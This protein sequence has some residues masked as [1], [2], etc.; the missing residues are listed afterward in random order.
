MKVNY[1]IVCA[2][3][4]E[5]ELVQNKILGQGYCWS[6]GKKTISYKNKP[7]LIFDNLNNE[8]RSL[9]YHN[10]LMSDDY[11]I[12]SCYNKHK[13]ISAMDFLKLVRF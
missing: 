1:I 4:Y 6:E 7:V 11:K 8:D 5:N 10:H 2:D 9:S 13:L 12:N 3:E